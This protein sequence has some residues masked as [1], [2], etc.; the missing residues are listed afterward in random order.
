MAC[1]ATPPFAGVRGNP[2]LCASLIIQ[3][4]NFVASNGMMLRRVMK[5]HGEC[6]STESSCFGGL[7][8]SRLGISR[9]CSR[10][11]RFLF[12]GLGCGDFSYQAD[13]PMDLEEGWWEGSQSGITRAGLV[14]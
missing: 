7:R 1:V 10:V 6:C 13:E 5:T 2:P 9:L 11:W 14:G 8:V 4:L 3:G 12:D